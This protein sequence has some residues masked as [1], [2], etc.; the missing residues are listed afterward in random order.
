MRTGTMFGTIAAAAALAACAPEAEVS[1]RSD[2][3]ALCSACHGADAKGVTAADALSK[4][5]PDLTRI[6][7]RN[8]GNFDY[9]SV[10]SR[11]DGYTRD[12]PGQA[13]PDFGALLEGETVL[14]DLGDGTLTPTP[15]RLFGLAQYLA[16]I[17]EVDGRP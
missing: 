13:M 2:F 15:A 12:D 7:A 3:M 14:V 6:A 10:M 11:I 9:A 5:P 8:G 1:G 17:Q 16:S 4:V